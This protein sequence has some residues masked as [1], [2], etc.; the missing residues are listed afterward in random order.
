MYTLEIFNTSP[1]RILCMLIPQITPLLTL[2]LVRT[3]Y[4]EFT[5]P[6]KSRTNYLLLISKE[7]I[8]ERSSLIMALGGIGIC[9][10]HARWVH[11][12]V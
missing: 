12:R 2:A 5:P 6:P 7:Y 8:V 10:M 11:I 1:L 9:D 4:E 3:W